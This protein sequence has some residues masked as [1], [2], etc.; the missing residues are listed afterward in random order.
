M[1]KC[2]LC[3]ELLGDSVNRC[4]NCQYD[5]SL[6]TQVIGNQKKEIYEKNKREYEKQR[7]EIKKDQLS[8]NPSFEYQII[9]VNNLATGELDYQTIQMHLDRLSY[10]G[11]RLHS[12]FDNELGKTSSSVAI[13]FIG[14]SVNATICQ[15]VLI[16]ER[17][18]KPATN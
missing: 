3:G 13:G 16:F 2:P 1:R 4:F 18:I 6:K 5:F 17:C 12:V 14:S 7:D 9:V 11:W 15:T 10:D 8:K